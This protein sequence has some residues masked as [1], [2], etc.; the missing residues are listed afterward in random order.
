MNKCYRRMWSAASRA[1]T[2]GFE[3]GVGGAKL[4]WSQ[5]MFQWP[6]IGPFNGAFSDESMIENGMKWDRLGGIPVCWTCWII[7]R[8][9]E[10][11]DMGSLFPLNELE[12]YQRKMILRVKIFFFNE[13]SLYMISVHRMPSYWY[14]LWHKFSC[15]NKLSDLKFLTITSV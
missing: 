5:V 6:T 8:R 15:K 4:W 1:M 11:C 7:Y 3:V 2:R 14:N 9:A 12:K 13:L 10:G